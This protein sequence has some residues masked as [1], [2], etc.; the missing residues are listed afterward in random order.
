MTK[1]VSEVAGSVWKVEVE[2]GQSVAAGDPPT[3]CGAM[4]HVTIGDAADAALAANAQA[5]RNHI[6]RVAVGFCAD[7]D[8]GGMVGERMQLIAIAP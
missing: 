5:F 3:G 8:V 6:C 7:H 1:V 4:H 2:V